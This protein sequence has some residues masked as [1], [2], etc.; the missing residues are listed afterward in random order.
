MMISSPA[1]W[2]AL[3]AGLLVVATGCG[4]LTTSSMAPVRG[5]V[6]YKG[7]PLTMGTIVFAPDALKGSTGPLAHATIQTDGS[8]ALQSGD[9]FGA[10]V[11]WHRVTVSAV[12]VSP[13]AP[14]E[15]FMVPR[16]LVP[17]KYRDPEL[18]GLACE[19]K[20]G[21]ENPINF[22]LE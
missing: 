16:S 2:T 8:Y 22:N 19:V 10:V 7:K 13:V 11:G 3:A 20:A 12:E 21:Q 1:R 18:S 9:T 17:E 6:S 4:K 15:R 14:G 5:K